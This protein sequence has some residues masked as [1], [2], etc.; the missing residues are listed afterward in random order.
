ME[1]QQLNG[2]PLAGTLQDANNTQL[3]ITS[4]LGLFD[5]TNEELEKCVIDL[6][7]QSTFPRFRSKINGRAQ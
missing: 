4:H 1:G 5:C 3:F 2:V 7:T 6:C